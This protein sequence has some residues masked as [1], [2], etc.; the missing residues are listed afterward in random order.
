MHARDHRLRNPLNR[1]HQLRAQIEFIPVE[2]EVAPFQFAEVVT[3]GERWA[4]AGDY[5]RARIGP[6]TDITKLG[7]QFRHH[8]GRQRVAFLGTVNR[9]RDQPGFFLHDQIPL[10][11]FVC[12]R[13]SPAF[14]SLTFFSRKLL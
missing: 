5:H 13:F 12:H 9:K 7:V 8:R 2:C 14:H 1:Q 10:P 6:F 11:V 3:G 4:V